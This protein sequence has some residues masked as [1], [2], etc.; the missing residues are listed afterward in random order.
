MK[1]RT[2]IAGIG[3]A[4]AWPVLAWGQQSGRQ[5]RIGIL[6]PYDE[7]DLYTSSSVAAFVREL[8]EHGW[9]DGQNLQIQLRW[10]GSDLVKI[11]KYASELVDLGPDVIFSASEPALAT[12][13]QATRS[14]PIVFVAV[15]DP[16]GSG[17]VAN[18][19]HPGGNVTGFTAYEYA[20]GG[21]WFQLL[22]ELAPNITRVGVLKD[23]GLVSGAGFI[24]PMEAS[25]RA[26][27]MELVVLDVRNSADVEHAIDSV[28]RKANS[29]LIVL[30]G[31]SIVVNR[32]LIAE[33]AIR[34][35]LPAM[36]TYRFF[37]TDGGLVSYGIDLP[38]TYRRAASYVSR[39]LKGERAGDLPVQAPTKFELVVNLKSA[40]AIGLSIPQPFLLLADEVIE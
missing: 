26:L 40:K 14:V 13:L 32:Q 5:R 27:G 38:E 8:M 7:G 24:L 3:S 2:F 33:L 18:L 39:I 1:K 36:Y 12:L 21:K 6:S 9:I 11:R 22:K 34:H 37:A 4:A 29:G 10:S 31:P 30:P 25:A 20:T 16:V 23:P 28:A 35:R 15:G 19:A 17:F